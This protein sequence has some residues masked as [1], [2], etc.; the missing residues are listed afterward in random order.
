MGLSLWGDSGDSSSNTTQNYDQSNR[1]A[2]S[3]QYGA[4]IQGSS[5]V[6][7]DASL[8]SLG[9]QNNDLA[10]NIL[11]H[12]SDTNAATIGKLADVVK[13][14]SNDTLSSAIASNNSIGT[15]AQTAQSTNATASG[16]FSGLSTNIQN[17][18]MIGAVLLGGWFLLG[19]PG[20]KGI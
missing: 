2:A 12:I 15:A 5:N 11:Q 17:M 9:I 19:H 1:S 18:V 6:V 7:N 16:L 13:Q 20:K 8:V 14:T 4:A 10:A 3:S